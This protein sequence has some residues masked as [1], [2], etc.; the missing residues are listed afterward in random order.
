MWGARYFIRIM[1]DQTEFDHVMNY[2][3][4]N[5]VI[6]GLSI[7]PEE[8]KAS[9]AYYKANNISGIVDIPLSDQQKKIKL[10]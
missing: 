10:L 1:E 6:V 7:T 2:I 3:D 4:Q 5:P 8:W 9:G